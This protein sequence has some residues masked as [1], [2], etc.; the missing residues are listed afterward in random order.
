M[1]LSKMDT[2]DCFKALAHEATICASLFTRIAEIRDS[3]DDE[4]E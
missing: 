3:V 4:E 2:T 1:S